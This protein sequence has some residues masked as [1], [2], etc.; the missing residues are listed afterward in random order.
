MTFQ[1]GEGIQRQA[2]ASAAWQKLLDLLIAT[3]LG[4]AAFTLYATTVAP[5]VLAGDGGEF[6][7]VPYLLGVAHP[8]GYP[9]YTMLGWL[10][11]HLL[12][13]GDVAYRM[14]LFSAFW[15][16]LA[17]A[18]VYPTVRALLRQVF[19]SLGSS[20]QRLVGILAALTFAVTPTL[21]SQAVIAEVY[22]LHIFFVVLIL[23]LLLGWGEHGRSR[24]LYLAALAFGLSLAHHSTT[25]LLAPAILVYVWL[26]E[27]RVYRDWRLML[28]LLLLLLL[29]LLLYLYIPLRAPQTPYLRLP[30]AKGRELVL[31]ENTWPNLVS[32][33]LGGPF[34]GSVDLSVD[35]GERLL[36][37]WGFLRDEVGWI[38]VVL[39]LVGMLQ[40]AVGLPSTGARRSWALLALTAITYVAAVAFN[41]V[42]TIGDI[43]VMYIPSYLVIVLWLALG[44]GTLASL[45]R[46]RRA[47]GTVLV[48]LCFVLPL[49]LSFTRYASVDQ[50]GNTGARSRWEAILAEP[51]PPDAVL[52]SNDR[53]N[54]M[55]MWYSQYVDGSRPDLLGL[56][57]LITPEYPTL[58]HVLDL[59]LNTDRPVYLIKEMP[60]IG[61][62]VDVEAAGRLW[63]VLGP[64]AG[65]APAHSRNAQ[66]G[67][68]MVL[69]GYDRSPHS[70]R[71]GETM[72]VSLYW[73]ALRPLETEYHSFIHLLDAEGHVVAQSDRQPG[74][75]YYPTTL[76]QP[77]ERLRDDHL[78]TIPADVPEGVYSL[79]AGM[80]ALS[81]DGTLQPLGEPAV[82]GRIGIKAEVPTEPGDVGHPV[83]A[84]FAGQI[85]LLGYDATQ[86]D[87]RL[88]VTFHWRCLQPPDDDY[89]VFVHLLDAGDRVVTQH[90]GQP[91]DGRYPT[92]I[93]DAG[94][95]VVDTHLLS[96]PAD[97]PA[98][99]YR[100]RV[101]LYLLESG[102]RLEVQGDGDSVELGPLL[103]EPTG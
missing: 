51:L 4:G 101:G 46:R 35:L 88:A 5:T 20:L 50:S 58:G 2:P 38:G 29:P 49:W 10:W 13:V 23:Y 45:F 59:A 97:L 44:V 74:G 99:Q 98:G 76:W 37:W 9:L 83:G 43:Y 100:L 6:Q 54:I 18:L 84:N 16:A 95:V 47:V 55:P 60:G 80:Y 64:A 94:E 70:P 62:K 34:R 19:P 79:L 91:Q 14:N 96:L 52:I 24:S 73:R 39:A 65:E 3:V 67:D 78:L 26:T 40:L 42:Y 41:L 102:E 71:P 89:T 63:Q 8:T 17:V 82:I 27:R 90:D 86:Q 15:A 69:V 31:Y 1:E 85:E 68:A 7:F 48:L 11:S 53:N 103:L 12:P 81:G 25:L 61:V 93:W 56:F 28:K 66:L 22:G 33:V 92:S 77:G 57:P 21:W 75:V 32:F 87:S 30:L 72:Q 36:M